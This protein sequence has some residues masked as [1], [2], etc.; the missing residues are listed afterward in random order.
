MRY[1]Y[2]F[3]RKCVEMYHQGLYPDTPDGLDTKRLTQKRTGS[4]PVLFII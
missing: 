3:K 2:E 4:R 1:S